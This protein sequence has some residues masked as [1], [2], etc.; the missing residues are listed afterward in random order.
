MEARDGREE[1][2][3]EGLAE[4]RA[5]KGWDVTLSPVEVSLPPPS[6]GGCPGGSLFPHLRPNNN[7]N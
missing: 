1:A 3:A 5:W 6:S 2:R 7:N 4:S